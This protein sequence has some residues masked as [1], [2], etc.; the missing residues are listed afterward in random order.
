MKKF[1]LSCVGGIHYL[2]NKRSGKLLS[3]ICSAGSAE[4]YEKALKFVEDKNKG[5]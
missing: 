1:T 4:N 2:A 3:F 5:L